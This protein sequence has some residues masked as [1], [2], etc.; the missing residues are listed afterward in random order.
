MYKL[1]TRAL[2]CAALVRNPRLQ[3]TYNIVPLY[4]VGLAPRA[5]YPSVIKGNDGNN[6]NSSCLEVCQ[7]VDVP[8]KVMG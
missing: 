5:H 1:P 3:E 4:V 7:M 2:L 8:R 6:I